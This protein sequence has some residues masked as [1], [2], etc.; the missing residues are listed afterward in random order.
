MANDKHKVIFVSEDEI[1]DYDDFICPNCDAG[2]VHKDYK[3]NKK[4]LYLCIFCAIIGAVLGA[5]WF[6]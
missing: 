4:T 6:S 1:E 3:L 5:A 2:L